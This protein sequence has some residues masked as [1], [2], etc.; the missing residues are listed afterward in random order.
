MVPRWITFMAALALTPL[1]LACS[2]E[3]ARPS[4]AGAGSVP[5]RARTAALRV[6]VTGNGSVA[7]GELGRSCSD[8][9]TYQVGR[10]KVVTLTAVD[11][12]D[13]F[14][15]WSPRC[16][17]A[18]DCDVEVTSNVVIHATFGLD[19]YEPEWAAAVTASECVTLNRL[20]ADDHVIVAGGF[21]GTATVGSAQ[22]VSTGGD[23]ALMAALGRTRGEVLWARSV[24]T[25]GF[26]WAVAIDGLPGKEIA[27]GL[28]RADPRQDKI[29]W[30]DPL[31]GTA[32]HSTPAGGVVRAIRHLDDS[33]V[34]S[35][36]SPGGTSS[37]S[38]LGR[39][40]S[41]GPAWIVHL[42]ATGSVSVRH[43]AAGPTNDIFIVGTLEGSPSFGA[44]WV[45]AP[46]LPT[47]PKAFLL[48]LDAATGRIM[49]ARWLDWH[50]VHLPLAFARMGR[51]LIVAGGIHRG[52]DTDGFIAA[53]SFDGDIQWEHVLQ[54]TR[55]TSRSL[56]HSIDASDSTILVAGRATG[57]VRL[58]KRQIGA[59]VQS[60]R[61]LVE[62]S[63]SGDELWFT[64]QLPGDTIKAV[65]RDRE[66]DVY[67][68]GA[69]TKPFEFAGRTIAPHQARR[70][71]NSAF[72]AKLART[73]DR[74]PP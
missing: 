74:T 31:R 23:D 8:D 3:V 6:R 15:G 58:G 47:S 39:S 1:V 34:L 73:G 16:G 24:G 43:L 61:F 4:L 49:G 18:A 26:D 36:Y 53:L 56:I 21:S 10:G 38:R 32:L 51:L 46:P 67:L 37:V 44:P 22:M 5:P 72:I 17:R 63:K 48:R 28:S 29:V 64:D 25:P 40:S 59:P 62:L 27:V 50:D 35:A 60:T 65:S 41:A 13:V 54:G 33:V 42:P 69:F 66:G 45:G 11:G 20:V 7:P 57:E 12:S 68:T 55:P 52:R 19:R 9:C 71:C 2:G 70:R 14:H 30:L